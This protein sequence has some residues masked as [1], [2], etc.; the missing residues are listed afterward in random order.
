LNVRKVIFMSRMW[1][2]ANLFK[3]HF[4]L[5]HDFNLTLPGLEIKFACEEAEKLGATIHFLGP[6][7]NQ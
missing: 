7:M 4:R 1:I 5:G 3:F 2:F 6:E